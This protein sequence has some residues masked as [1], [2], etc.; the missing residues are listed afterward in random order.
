MTV[1]NINEVYILAGIANSFNCRACSLFLAYLTLGAPKETKSVHLNC[2]VPLTSARPLWEL[3][4][5]PGQVWP[6]TTLDHILTSLGDGGCD[7]E[8]PWG[9][10]K[11]R[12]QPVC[13]E[14]TSDSYLYRIDFL[15]KDAIMS[16]SQLVPTVNLRI[17]IHT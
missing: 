14:K 12:W 10:R 17:S 5:H 13:V 11:T 9:R 1:C 16:I 7:G 6:W 8:L 2:S 15:Q 3:S 4:W